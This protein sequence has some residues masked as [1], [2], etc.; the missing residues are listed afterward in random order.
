MVHSA[1][2]KTTAV[3]IKPL[4]MLES[5]VS[6]DLN[7]REPAAKLLRNNKKHLA[8]PLPPKTYKTNINTKTSPPSFFS[9]KHLPLL[10]LRL[11]APTL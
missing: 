11:V 6:V 7:D 9:S 4:K 10:G 3:T 8:N 2:K 1:M 5:P